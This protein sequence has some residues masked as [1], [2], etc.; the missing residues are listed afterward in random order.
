MTTTTRIHSAGEAGF[1]EFRASPGHRRPVAKRGSVE[2]VVIGHTG[3]VGSALVQRL[4]RI[5]GQRGLPELKFSEGINRSRHIFADGREV[6]EL[7]RAS[8]SLGELAS[9][10][11]SRRRPAVIVDCT[12]DPDLPRL[13]PDWLRAGIGVVTPNKHGLAGD[14]KLYRAIRE[15]AQRSGAPLAYSATVGAGSPI[16]STLRR[17]RQAGAAPSGITAV[18]SGT[19]SHVFSAMTDGASLSEAVA[20]ARSRGFTEPNPLEDLSGR[21]VARKLRIMLREAGLDEIGIHREPVVPDAPARSAS[22]EP[23][24]KALLESL[25]EAWRRR[26]AQARSRQTVMVYLARFGQSGATVA[27]VCVAPDSPFARLAGSGNRACIEWPDDP[28]CPMD[29]FGPG[30]GTNVTAGAVLADLVEAASGLA[31]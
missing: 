23:A 26:L 24:V 30:A 7:P 4:T 2:V 1:V 8:G 12:A 17:M 29:I 31:R 25:D 20:D 9:R 19:L 28:D 27:P 14:E 21:D 11:G 22:D 16:L 10:L 6:R 3:Q 13:Y 18:L 5:G 15:A